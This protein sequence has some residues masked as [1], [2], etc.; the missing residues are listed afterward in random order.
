MEKSELLVRELSRLIEEGKVSSRDELA[1]AK[2]RLSG[3][4][5]LSK[6]PTNPD[7]LAKIKN[8][9]VKVLSLL[10]VKPLRTLSGVAPVAIMTRPWRCPHGVCIYCPGGLGSFF[11]DVPQSYTGHEPATMRGLKN[12]YSAYLQSF[13]RISQ[14]YATG[15][16][17]EKVELIIMGGTFP[18]MP[19]GYQNNF[20]LNA[21][22][23]FND[24]SDDFFD[25]GFNKSSF[26][27]YFGRSKS[28]HGEQKKFLVERQSSESS[29]KAL[30]REQERNETS[31][32]R[33]VTMCIETKPDWCK[34]AHI[35]QMLKLGATRVEL[36]VQ[37]LDEEVLRFTNR[38]HSLSD[39]VEAT[40]LLKDS[41]LK[42]TYHFMPGQPF[43]SME[44]DISML[45]ELFDNESFRPDGLKIYPCMPMP[46]TALGRLYEV[47]KFVPL[48][49]DEAA[50]IISEATSSFPEYTRVHRV[51]RDI[52]VKFALGGIDKNNL[53]QIVDKKCVEKGIK[54][55]C[56]R[57]REVGINS[58]K[59]VKESNIELVER[60][61]RASKGVEVFL[62]FEDSANDLLIGFCRL[63]MPFE[64][65]RP[66]FTN[67]TA[68]IRELHVFGSQV[69]IGKKSLDSEQHKGFG[70]SL[71][72]MAEQIAKE[73]FG[74]DKLLVISGVGAREYY[75]NKLGYV[76]DGIYMA[77]ML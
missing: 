56:I 43:T 36:G 10:S 33:V 37:T 53:R 41:G 35:S 23:A 76:R 74:A 48:S 51:Q 18:A 8:P 26:N 73:S 16:N 28:G 38:G 19:L 13:N 34:E 7:I 3:E 2:L 11:G 77:K 72:R 17:P 45:K 27:S 14:Y 71:V 44:N 12:D 57:C 1:R 58:A 24:F 39:T 6:V 64:P 59:K 9:S 31:A 66:E 25:T 42:V 29:D 22:K 65:F 50:E 68:V 5:G 54:C 46:G 15:H 32:I 61:Y 63:R 60:R 47:G 21:F 4:L 20:V 52:P 55:R 67:S 40:R 75:K 30:F 49:T 69:G 70:V 62:S